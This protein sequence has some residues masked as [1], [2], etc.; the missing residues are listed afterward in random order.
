MRCQCDASFNALRD[1]LRG[2]HYQGG[3]A[4]RAQAR[5]PGARRDLRRLGRCE[6]RFAELLPLASV[7]LTPDNA[8]AFCIPKG[9]AHGFQTLSDGCEVFYQM[10]CAYM[11]CAARGVRF[12][13]PMFAIDWPER[14]GER[15]VSARDARYP[16]FEP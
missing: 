7:E 6:A 5:P 4:W 11:P 2:K 15:I 9:M 14:A 16:D 12:D 8:L 10:G 13:D 3:T 1:A